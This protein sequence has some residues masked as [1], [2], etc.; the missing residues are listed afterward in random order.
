M[1]VR[2]FTLIELLVVIAII[3]ILASML[4]PALSKARAS[5]QG[6]KCLSNIKQIGLG[7]A[8][9][10]GDFNDS[11]PMQQ[12]SYAADVEQ[13]DTSYPGKNYKG[14]I[15]TG[16][17]WHQTWMDLIHPYTG[18]I[19]LFRCPAGKY[20]QW[21]PSYGYNSDASGWTFGGATTKGAPAKVTAFKNPSNFITHI[22]F[23]ST[24]N[25][26]EPYYFYIVVTPSNSSY[27]DF[28]SR[29]FVHGGN[30]ASTL[31]VDGHATPMRSSGSELAKEAGN[32]GVFSKLY[33]YQEH[34]L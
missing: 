28:Y 8:M 15:Y 6:A 14:G 12:P 13:T 10:T 23:G 32:N 11:L 20:D 29:T 24:Y 31:Y 7:V 18:S 16:D 26:M 30:S 4:L 1:K 2:D 3:A 33:N 34:Q 9:Y 22:D 27:T 19:A 25:K 21:C 5:A 17:G